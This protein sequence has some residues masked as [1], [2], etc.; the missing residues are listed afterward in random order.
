MLEA[1]MHGYAISVLRNIAVLCNI[2]VFC[3][4]AVL[5]VLI[6]G[7]TRGGSAM[8]FWLN[9]WGSMKT[10]GVERHQK[11]INSFHHSHELV[12]ER[13]FH[14]MEASLWLN[15]EVSKWKCCWRLVVY[16]MLLGS[17]RPYPWMIL[18]ENG[19]SNNDD[20]DCVIMQ[21]YII[22]QYCITNYYAILH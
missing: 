4:T 19:H 3:N 18:E 20:E 1:I 21:Y 8:Y 6:C 16:F 7:E 12:S 14:E 5:S 13:E 11:R 2:T 22:M 9:Q 17:S 15:E 10:W